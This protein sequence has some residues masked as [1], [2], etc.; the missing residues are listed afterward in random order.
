VDTVP[1]EQILFHGHPSWLSM[2]AFHVKGVVAAIAAGVLAGLVSAAVSGTVNVLWVVLA[3]LAVF[4][5][6]IARGIV[7]RKRTSYTITSERL[8]IQ[9]GLMSR[10]LHE[11]RLDRVQNVSTRQ[12]VLERLLG[13]GTVDFDTAGGAA[14]DF[15]FHGVAH[16]RQ[17][18]RT[19]DQALRGQAF[20]R[21]EARAYAADPSP[22]SA[23]R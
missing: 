7:R 6:V 11:T 9:L 4:A 15:S 8:T 17:I 18:V 19:V 14:F 3:V 13:V 1:S 12:S 20:P 10:E 2:L 22:P 5:L 21:A 16:P 23:R